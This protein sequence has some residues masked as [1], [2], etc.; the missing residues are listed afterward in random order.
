MLSVQRA[1]CW[2]GA[3]SQKSLSSHRLPFVRPWHRHLNVSIMFS[4][5]PATSWHIS[6]YDSLAR[7]FVSWSS[8]KCTRFHS[9][10]NTYHSNTKRDSIKY[11]I[12]QLSNSNISNCLER[13]CTIIKTGTRCT[14]IG[15]NFATVTDK[16][17]ST[18]TLVSVGAEWHTRPA[19]LTRTAAAHSCTMPTAHILN[20]G[21]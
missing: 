6:C 5:T 19:V 13:I 14:R 15:V 3:E 7:N 10:I 4:H 17:V 9:I 21:Q 18:V 1:P 11:Q 2:H 12:I 8:I 16:S 20:I